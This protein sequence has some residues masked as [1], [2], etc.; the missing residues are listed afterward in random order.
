MGLGKRNRVWVL[1]IADVLLLSM[2]GTAKRWLYFKIRFSPS[3]RLTGLG[4][5]SQVGLIS[6]KLRIILVRKG[7]F[8]VQSIL[9]PFSAN[10]WRR[11][12]PSVGGTGLNRESQIF[13]YE[14]FLRV[15]VNYTILTGLCNEAGSQLW[16]VSGK[17]HTR[18]RKK[19]FST[20]WNTTG[21]LW[22]NKKIP[23]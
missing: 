23:V 9:S 6:R 18:F 15:L 11:N 2:V 1:K 19:V 12:R 4:L 14:F 10:P 22:L 7:F 17:R 16:L 13:L 5:T 3:V 20:E 21:N 8:P